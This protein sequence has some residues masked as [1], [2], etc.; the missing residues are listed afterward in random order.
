MSVDRLAAV[1]EVTG[2]YFDP[3]KGHVDLNFI[4]EG[5]HK[6]LPIPLEEILKCEE[7]FIKIRQ[8]I[9]SSVRQPK[10]QE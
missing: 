8:S 6:I 5:G 4:S 1:E 2:V 7:W 10:N 3:V 9:A